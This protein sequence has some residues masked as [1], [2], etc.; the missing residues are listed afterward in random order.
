L[1]QSTQTSIHYL[2][3]VS[4]QPNAYVTMSKIGVHVIA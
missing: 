3:T 1:I 2:M 4:N